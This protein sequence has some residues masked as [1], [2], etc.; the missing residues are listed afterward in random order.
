MPFAAPPA[1]GYGLAQRHLPVLRF[2][3]H[4][5]FLPIAVGYSIFTDTAPSKSF[6]RHLEFNSAT[7]TV[8]EYAIWWDWDIQHLYELEHLWVWLDEQENVLRFEGSWHGD[9]RLLGTQAQG[10]PIQDG[11]LSVYS[12][13][14]KH[15]FAATPQAFLDRAT[16]TRQACSQ[17]AGRGGVLVTPLFE[18]K[19][20]ARTALNNRLVQTFCHT[21]RFDPSYDFS[22]AFDLRY[23][24]L[25]A[26]QQMEQWIPHR[27]DRVLA[28]LNDHFS[29]ADQHTLRI[30]DLSGSIKHVAELEN[31][32]RL[33]HM[34]QA[35][36]LKMGLQPD[37]KHGFLLEWL[38]PTE[39]FSV[40]MTAQLTLYLQVDL[41]PRAMLPALLSMFHNA[42]VLDYLIFGASSV[43]SIQQI[44]HHA[45]NA[46]TILEVSD[47]LNPQTFIRGQFADYV[48]GK[49]SQLLSHDWVQQFHRMGIGVIVEGQASPDGAD[50]ICAKELTTQPE[51]T[52]R[53]PDTLW[54]NVYQS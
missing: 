37:E 29:I 4:E 44:K 20:H 24:P 12:E 19:I 18:G 54:Q 10:L 8:I 31:R 47:L 17:A 43:D 49:V 38:T 46:M 9:L 7:H 39:V 33:A 53:V 26:W 50:G 25:M 34:Q 21:Q 13:P 45:P 30:V 40:L 52:H 23:V 11:R 22:L 51:R 35:D 28:E 16:V 36:V 3:A 1:S 6:P 27:V 32:V 15:A 14:G 48:A 2:D 41:L 42:V 5:P